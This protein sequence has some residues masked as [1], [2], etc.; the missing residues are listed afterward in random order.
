MKTP[1]APRK[2][3]LYHGLANLMSH[4]LRGPIAGL[5]GYAELLGTDALGPA[6]HLHALQGRH[7]VEDAVEPRTRVGE[8]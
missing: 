2:R 5:L 6:G 3:S 8:T 1:T 4:E 7:H